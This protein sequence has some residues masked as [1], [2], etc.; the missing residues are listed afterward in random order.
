M[1]EM[2]S[3]YYETYWTAEGYNPTGSMP[4]S[5]RRLFEQHV[6]TGDRCLDVGC[7]DGGTSGVWLQA[8]AANYVG[9]N[10]SRNA[11]RLAR[12]RGLDAREI[13][14]ADRLPF[15]ADA[16]DLAV[17][18]EVFEHLFAPQAAAAEILRVLSA[19]GLLIATV[20]SIAFWRRRVDLLFGRWNAGG[21]DLGAAKPW[22]SPHIRFFTSRQL[23][24]ML[25]D[26][27][28]DEVAVRGTTDAPLLAHV[29]VL[30]RLSRGEASAFY[31]FLAERSPSLAAPGLLALAR[32][33]NGMSISGNASGTANVF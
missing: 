14:D 27:G 31:R 28:F 22:R 2:T 5:L 23:G 32:K 9:V 7:G 25:R 24:A 17:C 30:N 29:P 11:I 1:P 13:E 26:V 33:E 15:D 18:I 8:H 6:R 12:E 10:I 21:D 3:G 20:P 19:G 4:T 16:F